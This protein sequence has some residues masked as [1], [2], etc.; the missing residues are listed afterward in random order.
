MN[1]CVY[2]L[3]CLLKYE[4]KVSGSESL[5]DSFLTRR[6]DS[7]ADERWLFSYDNSICI[8]RNRRNILLFGK[9]KRQIL[10][11]FYKLFDILGSCAAATAEYSRSHLGYC[12]HIFA[13][14][15]GIYIIN[16]LAVPYLGKS[17]VRLD[18]YRNRGA[19]NESLDSRNHLIGAKG[20]VHSDSIGTHSF[21]QRR[22]S[23]GACARHK[24]SALIVNIHDKY[25]QIAVFLYRKKCR[26]CLKRIVHRLDDNKVN[27]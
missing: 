2:L 18:D 14:F 22:H 20:A 12:V 27:A 26:L 4:R 6:V 21:E 25:G 7:L 3:E 9:C 11:R 5:F 10:C 24:L 19:L 15:V 16:S 8:R 13:E 1:S 17:C 23:L